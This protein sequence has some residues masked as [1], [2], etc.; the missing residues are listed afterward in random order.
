VIENQPKHCPFNHTNCL[1]DRCALWV[2]LTTHTQGPIPEVQNKTVLGMC[3]FI[4]NLQAT[5]AGANKPPVMMAPP[6][7]RRPLV[8]G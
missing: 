2:E 6:V 7:M 8:G 5:V 4:A 3:V 1:A